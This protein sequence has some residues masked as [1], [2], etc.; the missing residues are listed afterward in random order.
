[1]KE[2]GGESMGRNIWILRHAKAAPEGA[3]GDS[4]RPL[5]GRGRR[6]ADAVREHIEALKAKGADLPSLVLCSPAVRALQ[7][8]ERVT[9]A[10]P[11]ARLEIE[12][13]LYTEGAPG[14]MSWLRDMDPDEESLMLVGHNP[15]L[16]EICLDLAEP[17]DAEAIDAD[18]LPT[19][20]LVE[21]KVP[22]LTSWRRLGAGTLQLAHQFFPDRW[23]RHKSQTSGQ[24]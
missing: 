13:V 21:L 18:G 16:L 10:I 9:P 6:Q 12:R 4:A 14:V 11:D 15:T 23:L 19:A 24:G 17:Q 5:T 8:A 20:G 7:T 1:M 2:P 22:D 3:G